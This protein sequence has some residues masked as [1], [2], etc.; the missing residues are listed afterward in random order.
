[1][2]PGLSAPK[3]RGNLKVCSFQIRAPSEV[4]NDGVGN[5][6]LFQPNGS[7]QPYFVSAARRGA[8]QDSA[9][10]LINDLFALDLGPPCVMATQTEAL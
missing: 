6:V 5:V 10:G 7:H 2:K 8:G 4:L 9:N 1:M 3:F